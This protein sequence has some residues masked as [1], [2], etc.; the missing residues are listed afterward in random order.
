MNSSLKI[1]ADENGYFRHP[2][3]HPL[4]V[5]FDSKHGDPKRAA[6]ISWQHPIIGVHPH[7][8]DERTTPCNK[9]ETNCD[10]TRPLK[11]VNISRPAGHGRRA[12]KSSASRASQK[13][14]SVKCGS[15]K[16]V[17]RACANVCENTLQINRLSSASESQ[18]LPQSPSTR[19]DPFATFPVAMEPY[20]DT[21]LHRYFALAPSIS[22]TAKAAQGWFLLAMTDAALFHSILCGSA[23]YMDLLTGRQDSVER[24]THMKESVHLLNTRLQVP[25]T[26]LSDSTLFAVALLAEFE[27]RMLFFFLPPSLHYRHII[28]FAFW[29]AVGNFANWELHMAGLHKM[30]QLRGGLSALEEQFQLKFLQADLTGSISTLSPSRFLFPV[31]LDFEFSTSDLPLGL[32]TIVASF[33]EEGTRTPI[34]ADLQS[35]VSLPSSLALRRD[36]AVF[37]LQ[38]RLLSL[39]LSAQSPLLGDTEELCALAAL[40]YLSQSQLQGPNLHSPAPTKILLSLKLCLT[41]F[42]LTP[43]TRDFIFWVTFVGAVAA[44]GRGERSWF[45]ARVVRGA[46]ECGISSWEEAKYVVG[47]FLWVEGMQEEWRGVWE[48]AVAVREVLYGW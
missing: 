23:L 47:N 12:K 38:H 37:A 30:V 45:V 13:L 21:L 5:I 4:V 31:T 20:M 26:A 8:P 29:S 44:K 28:S 1:T 9:A 39:N 24:L 27:A 46:I 19:L 25:D 2:E 41:L 14:Q 33:P 17:N 35:L 40:L 42:V 22:K 48:E 16:S 10:D 11:F 7:K 43:Q 18:S 34:L 32:Q 36:H 6:Q 15:R 3:G